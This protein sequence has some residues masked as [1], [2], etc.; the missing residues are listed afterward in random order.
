[1]EP[2]ISTPEFLIWTIEQTCPLRGALDG[3]EPGRIERQLRA[4]RAVSEAERDGR[5]FEGLC[6]DPPCGFRIDEALTIYGGEAAA[7]RACGNCPVNALAE[8]DPAGL[9]GCF[10]ILALPD[11]ATEFHAA[12]GRGIA[13][14]SRFFPNTRPQWYGLWLSR[15]HEAETLRN[16]FL[17]LQAARLER[18]SVGDLLMALNTS[19]NLGSR[20][21]T[22][23]YPPGQVEG[24]W[25][26]LA[27]HC[28]RCKA[29]WN[30]CG[31]G[32][33]PVCGYDGHPAAEKKRHARGRRPYFP[34]AR[35][36]GSDQAAGE[37]LK[38]Y[39]NRAMQTQSPD[40]P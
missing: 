39:E 2:A 38:R 31:R 7:R 17:V 29:V 30:D 32:E 27:P 21:Y 36:L 28:P 25:W 3:S 1:M 16:L 14:R 15:F 6:I 11:D 35:L 33:C 23:L 19:Y 37:F 40:R 24:P 13:D 18:P 20:L 10:G 12:I 22:Q 4:A 34:L 8:T 5:V 9:A 26:R